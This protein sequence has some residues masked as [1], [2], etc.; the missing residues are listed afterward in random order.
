[1]QLGCWKL[2][3]ANFGGICCGRTLRSAAGGGRL[4]RDLSTV[5]DLMLLPYHQDAQCA[6]NH[7][8]HY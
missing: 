2:W 4:K 5:L 8:G 7:N 1:N 6:D 3:V